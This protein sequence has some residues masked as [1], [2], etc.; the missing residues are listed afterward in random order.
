[1][2]TLLASLAIE[3]ILH[4]AVTQPSRCTVDGPQ[5]QI[6]CL[7]LRSIISCKPDFY[8]IF[9]MDTSSSNLTVRE[10]ADVFERLERR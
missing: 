4:Y 7:C 9:I 10:R 1:M 2:Y 5:I 3:L 8:F 6:S